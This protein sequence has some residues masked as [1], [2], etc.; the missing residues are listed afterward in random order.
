LQQKQEEALIEQSQEES[1]QQ[2]RQRNPG[3]IV[4]RLA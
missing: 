2:A 3:E 1:Y 4:Q